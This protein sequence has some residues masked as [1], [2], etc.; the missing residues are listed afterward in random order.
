MTTRDRYA[1]ET[2][3]RRARLGD[4]TPSLRGRNNKRNDVPRSGQFPRTVSP[5]KF[6]RTFSREIAAPSLAP[7]P[8]ERITF[9]SASLFRRIFLRQSDTSRFAFECSRRYVL[10]PG[11]RGTRDHV[12]GVGKQRRRGE[13]SEPTICA[14]GRSGIVIRPCPHLHREETRPAVSVDVGLT[15]SARRSSS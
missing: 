11:E 5:M 9:R 12:A 1:K 3:Q 2:L 7:E 15:Y 10:S 13:K 14:H 6:A 4:F 8:P